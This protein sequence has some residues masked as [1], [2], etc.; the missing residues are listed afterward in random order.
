MSVEGPSRYVRVN[1]N[2]DGTK[3][4]SFLFVVSWFRGFVIVF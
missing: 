2:H 4:K 3:K 1:A